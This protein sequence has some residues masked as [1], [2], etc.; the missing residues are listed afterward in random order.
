MNFSRC[1]WAIAAV[2]AMASAARGEGGHGS[3][4]VNP[5]D[6]QTDL[7]L[8]SLVVFLVLLAVLWRF[9][10]RPITDGLD[11]RER[12]IAADIAAAEEANR[13]ARRILEDYQKRLA[14]AG[15]EVRRILDQGRRESEQAGREI[16]EKARTETRAEHQ[17]ALREIDN[18][19]DAA[20]ADLARNS[21]RLAVELAGKIVAA[22]LD[23]AG[24]QRLIDE[25]VAG[26]TGRN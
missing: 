22:K 9:A 8:W 3:G 6:F 21:A 26:F 23:A 5:L 12:R 2:G 15:D 4:A 19:T 24:H 13:D 20:L 7:A 18:A 25:A 1:T 11:K 16:I 14:A 10:W 17:R